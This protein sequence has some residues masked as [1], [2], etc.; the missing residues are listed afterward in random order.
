MIDTIIFT[1]VA[2]LYTANL[3]FSIKNKRSLW[4]ILGEIFIILVSVIMAIKTS[5]S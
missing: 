3:V 1:A 2:I 4:Y 5:I